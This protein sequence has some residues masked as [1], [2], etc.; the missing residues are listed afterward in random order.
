M[1]KSTFC[2]CINKDVDQ[3]RS[4]LAADQYLCF[5]HKDS[6]IPLVSKEKISNLLAIF[7]TAK[8]V[9]DLIRNPADR[10]SCHKA[11]LMNCK[12]FMSTEMFISYMLSDGL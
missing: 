10:F 12:S 9:S 5:H 7:C 3:L 2:I 1:R 8:F 11:F 6:T 4:N